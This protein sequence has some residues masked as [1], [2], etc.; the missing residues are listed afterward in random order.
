MV[1]VRVGVLNHDRALIISGLILSAPLLAC[2]QAAAA[3][4]QAP[5]DLPGFRFGQG[6]EPSASSAPGSTAAPAH[7]SDAGQDLPHGAE[8]HQRH[9]PTRFGE[10]RL[11]AG[12]V[13]T[14]KEKEGSSSN[15]G[16]VT[17]GGSPIHANG[18]TAGLSFC[19][20][21]AQPESGGLV[22]SIGVDGANYNTT[23]ATY[24]LANGTTYSS[25]GSKL[26]LT[27]VGLEL[28]AG[29]CYLTEPDPEAGMRIYIEVGPFI[30]G[31]Y[32]KG[33]TVTETSA[34]TFGI[35]NGS[36]TYFDG[37][38]RLGLHLLFGHVVVG[39]DASYMIGRV[40]VSSSLPGGSTGKLTFTQSGV[41]GDAMLGW[42]F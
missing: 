4:N 6:Q 23:P 1:E 12:I 39:A 25:S 35:T 36:G 17:F 8:E 28:F 10:W 16:A 42:H 30:G 13:P 26:E 38:L 15:P 22:W 24:E 40:A 41:G 20:G 11:V 29:G 37:G 7:A 31:G 32:A 34:A 14:P 2:A 3:D 5:A 27:T 21:H 9:D 18:Q 33:Q 19:Q